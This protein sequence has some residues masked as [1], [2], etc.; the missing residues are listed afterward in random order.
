MFLS[1]LLYD[2][3]VMAPCLSNNLLL[4]VYI[5]GL[6]VSALIIYMRVN[7]LTLLHVLQVLNIYIHGLM[8]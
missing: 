7:G 8:V 2:C 6:I 1:D 3:Q 5:H 4:I